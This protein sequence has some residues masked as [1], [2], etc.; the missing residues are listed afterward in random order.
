MAELSNAASVRSLL[1]S[2][3]HTRASRAKLEPQEHRLQRSRHFR[4]ATRQWCR[5]I[6]VAQRRSARSRWREIHPRTWESNR[7]R[8]DQ[9]HP[10]RRNGR[11]GQRLR[12]RDARWTALARVGPGSAQA[13]PA[14]KEPPGKK[15]T[16]VR[17]MKKPYPQNRN[18]TSAHHNWMREGL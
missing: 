12:K 1:G 5:T 14:R 6:C 9:S 16:R 4:D 18:P 8:V 15:R 10:E 11:G 2:S 13:E 17:E 3:R 7:C